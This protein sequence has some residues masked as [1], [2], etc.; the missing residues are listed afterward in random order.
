MKMTGIWLQ[1]ILHILK[2]TYLRSLIAIKYPIEKEN[3][4]FSVCYT[5]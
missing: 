4:L 3:H 2:K 1:S 5:V